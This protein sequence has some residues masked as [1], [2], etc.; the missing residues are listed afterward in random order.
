MAKQNNFRMRR[1]NNPP[2]STASDYVPHPMLPKAFWVILRDNLLRCHGYSLHA[3][4]YLISRISGVASII[5]YQ[6]F[7]LD[8][9]QQSCQ[10]A[11]A[12]SL[13]R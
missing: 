5:G 10:D 6:Q 4:D 13:P 7:L 8:D 3:V 11:I 9:R 2:T 12:A 1:N